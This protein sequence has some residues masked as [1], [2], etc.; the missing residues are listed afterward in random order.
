VQSRDEIARPKISLLLSDIDGTL[1][2]KTK[3]LT[4]RTCQAVYKLNAAG[5]RFAITSAR[6]PRGMKRFIEPLKITTPIACFNGGMIVNPDLSV[7][8]RT[9][10]PDSVARGVIEVIKGYKVD[11]W[12]YRDNEWYISSRD[13]HHVDREEKLLETVPV[14]TEDFSQVLD[15][16]AKIVA[17]SDDYDCLAQCEANL[18]KT[19]AQSCSALRSRPY[20]LDVT[21]SLANKGEVVKAFARHL[22]IDQKEIATIGD[23]P[24][25]ALMF[26][27]SGLS[28]AMGNASLEVQKQADYVTDSNENEGFAKAV[29]QYLLNVCVSS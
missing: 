6:A 10:L 22:S 23:M 13:S 21:S 11:V 7:L 24:T 28:I 25:D 14:V 9:V 29:E 3:E 18:Q 5:I 12:I 20:Y 8:E 2:T 19:F 16:I 27:Q 26:K 4:K 15:N 17:V 1:V